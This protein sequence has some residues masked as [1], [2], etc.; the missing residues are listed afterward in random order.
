MREHSHT[1][2]TWSEPH[3][4][5][6]VSELL[7]I[8]GYNFVENSMEASLLKTHLLKQHRHRIIRSED[9]EED[10]PRPVEMH[11]Q[12]PT[13][14]ISSIAG[15][16]STGSDPVE[17]DT[18]IVFQTDGQDSPWDSDVDGH[19]TDTST[20]A[21][22]RGHHHGLDEKPASQ[23]DSSDIS[24]REMVK[25][26]QE[27][28]M[29][30]DTPSW[31]KKRKKPTPS[32]LLLADSQVKYWLDNDGV[33]Q[34]QYHQ[35][36]PISRWT[37]S[38]RLGLIRIECGT[39]V[40]YLESVRRWGD[41]TPIKNALNTLCRNIRNHGNNPRIFVANHLPR[42][43]GSPLRSPILASNFTLQQATRSVGRAMGRVFELSLHEHFVSKK[44]RVIQPVGDYFI[45][46]GVLTHL[47]CLV[48]RECIM[49]ESGVKNYWFGKSKQKRAGTQ[50]G[51]QV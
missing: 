24:D 48:M 41:I 2:T 15:C 36:W 32:I 16:S 18:E 20:L 31:I 21:Y 19:D 14:C 9:E 13:P 39:V 35:D 40:L 46:S 51:S 5:M 42:I 27:E 11:N 34:V 49:R 43:N 37:Q 4:G 6:K 33:C 45:D 1:G 38:I 28:G 44:G 8:F 30:F 26:I 22:K 17:S 23:Q 25:V 50:G 12:E 10:I 29:K 7:L 3:T 47:G